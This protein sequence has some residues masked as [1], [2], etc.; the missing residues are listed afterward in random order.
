[1]KRTSGVFL[2]RGFCHARPFCAHDVKLTEVSYQFFC[3]TTRAPVGHLQKAFLYHV[4]KRPSVL[5]ALSRPSLT[6]RTPYRTSEPT[7]GHM[8]TLTGWSADPFSLITVLVD[9]T[10]F[11]LLCGYTDKTHSTPRSA[12]RFCDCTSYRQ[13][14]R[15]HEH[16]P[17]DAYRHSPPLCRCFFSC[18][19][20]YCSQVASVR[21]EPVPS[22]YAFP[23]LFQQGNHGRK[24][25]GGG[26]GGER[27]K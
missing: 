13:D 27:E 4:C 11:G 2:Y 14:S 15:V 9:F 21:A 16:P 24:A 20:P 17:I 3:A 22:R 18:P 26:G 10:K 23:Q 19:P 12:V 5:F 25:P 6:A 7:V 1:M 8:W